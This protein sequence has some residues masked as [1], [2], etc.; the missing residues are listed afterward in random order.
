MLHH[1]QDHYELR[2]RTRTRAGTAANRRTR[3]TLVTLLGVA[4]LA[5]C[6][7]SDNADEQQSEAAI[8]ETVAQSIAATTQDAQ[9]ETLALPVVAE[10]ARDGDLV[11]RITTRGNV[12]SDAT[13]RLNSEVSGTVTE[14]LVRPGSQVSKNQTLVKLDPYPFDL[15][16]REAQAV[17]DE[18]EQRFLE[19]FVPESL[20]TK[21]GPTPEQRRALMNRTGVAAARIRLERVMWEQARANILSPVSGAVDEIRVAPGE[22]VSAGQHLLT[23]VDTRNIRIET[24][25]LE[26][27]LPLIRVGGEAMVSSAG[28][29]NRILHGRI[30]AI[31][32]LV[33][34][35]AHA[36]RAIVRINSSGINDLLRPGMYVDV[37]LE[38]NRLRNRRLVPSRAVVERD[39]RPLVFVIRDGRA[40]W[41]Y[42]EAGRNNGIET[43]ILPDSISGI[44]PVN[45]GDMVVVDGHLTLT[46]DAPVRVT[47][48]REQEQNASPGSNRTPPR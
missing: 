40:Q 15:A 19:S 8:S 31:L 35:I 43:E 39:G 41:T 20:I 22:K 36:G 45:A 6:S 16:V 23:V 48:V 5:A 9:T 4:A 44:I 29:P 33:D 42:V 17:A 18:A 32:P 24:Q 14:L 21:V 46:H 25:V 1:S 10:P 37:Q 26:H 28:A 11:L 7:S 34:S 12:R 13:V 47:A 3:N 38:A 2:T 27:D 30:E